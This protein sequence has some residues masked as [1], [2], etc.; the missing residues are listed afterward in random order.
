MA[1][2]F[3]ADIA[4]GEP[5]RREGGDVV[6]RAI[7]AT[8]DAPVVA[9]AGADI[10]ELSGLSDAWWT[11]LSSPTM[12]YADVF[13]GQEPEAEGMR[14]AHHNELLFDIEESDRVRLVELSADVLFVGRESFVDLFCRR[15]QN[16]SYVFRVSATDSLPS[17]LV[18]M[19]SNQAV[20]VQACSAP[21]H[22][23]GQWLRVGVRPDGN[24]LVGRVDGVEIGRWTD[25][26]YDTGA[27]G[28]RAGFLP[29]T[30]IRRIQVVLERDGDDSPTV[31][32]DLW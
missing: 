19:A 10:V 18:K 15:R 17:S 4:N 8:D 27:F 24:D 12:N 6:E 26:D 31:Y 22:P 5:R 13:A 3:V 16:D 28:L 20:R 9:P 23:D 2:A 14:L 29:E 32:R 30:I 1:L 7:P 25:D 21:S 11:R